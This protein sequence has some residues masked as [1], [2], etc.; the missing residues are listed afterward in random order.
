MKR[1]SRLDYAFAVGRVKAL[2][3][4]LIPRQAFLEAADAEDPA[5]ALKLLQD[6]GKYPEDLLRVANSD[7]LDTLLGKQKDLLGRTMAE[8]LPEP[9][10]LQIFRA[11]HAPEE[12]LPLSRELPYPFVRDYVRHRLDLANIKIF[13]RMK[14]LGLSGESL[15]RRVLE[16][17]FVERAFYRQAFP[18][19]LAEAGRL[20]PYPAYRQAWEQSAQALEGR[21]TFI[22]L[23]REIEDFLMNYLREAKKLT[24]GPEPVFAY[25]LAYERELNLVRLVGVG[26][27][28]GVP[29]G[30]IK[31]RI[32]G[33]YV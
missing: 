4:Y 25:G 23:E 27:I 33:T 22:V 10:L 18:L 21:G 28:N 8:L 24:F 2:E 3:V 15:E 31:E 7:G 29:A 12:M 32:S 19:A 9:D 30:I 1:P 20:L 14:Y 26:K 5:A 6:A 11:D 13:F 16:G 17:G